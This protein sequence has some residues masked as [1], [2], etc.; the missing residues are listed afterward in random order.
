A[1]VIDTEEQLNAIGLLVDGYPELEMLDAK[2]EY[3]KKEALKQKLV[4]KALE[5]VLSRK[6]F[7]E[8]N[9]GVKLTIAGFS[10]VVHGEQ[11]T[12]GASVLNKAKRRV[13]S[14]LSS[15]LAS[16]A[17]YADK[18]AVSFDEFEYQASISLRFNVETQP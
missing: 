8:Q 13:T 12:R 14:K 11:E 7:Y 4:T 3:S 6:Q 5:D 1:I 16:K 10:D 15:A 17:S 18:Q 2:Y 9:L